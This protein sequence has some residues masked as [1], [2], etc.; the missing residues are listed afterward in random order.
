MTIPLNENDMSLQ[1]VAKRGWLRACCTR[2]FIY[3]YYFLFFIWGECVCQVFSS[4]STV[5]EGNWNKLP[6][7]EEKMVMKKDWFPAMVH[8]SIKKYDHVSKRKA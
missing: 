7:E 4:K 1:L 5:V 2:L 3:F 8:I 6:T